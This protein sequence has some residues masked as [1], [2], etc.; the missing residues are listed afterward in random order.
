MP[1]C[2]LTFN[3]IRESEKYNAE[4]GKNVR[5]ILDTTGIRLYFGLD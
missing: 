3:K 5:K 2:K 1:A 4:V